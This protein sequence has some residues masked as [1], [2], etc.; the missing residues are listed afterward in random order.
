MTKDL[1]RQIIAYE[2][3]DMAEEDIIPFFKMLIK[4]GIINHLQ[5]HYQRTARDMF[6]E[7]VK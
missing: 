6:I 4:S 2:S 5:G 3:G 7:G 1:V